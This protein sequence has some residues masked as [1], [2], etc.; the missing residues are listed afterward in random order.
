MEKQI[1][2]IEKSSEIVASESVAPVIQISQPDK[3]LEMAISKGADMDQLDKLLQLKERYD[4]EMARKAFTAAL[5]A[6]KTEDLCIKKDRTVTIET[7]DAGTYGYTHASLGNIVGTAVPIMSKHGL[8]HRW[9]TVQADARVKVT[10]ILTHRD[11]HSEQTTLEASPDTSGKKNG[12]QQ[13][14]STVTYLQRY[15]F[16]S[17]TG[18]AVEEMDNDGQG[19]E[20]QQI[21]P[22]KIKWDKVESA[23]EAFKEVVDADVDEMD[24]GR[25]QEGYRRLSND[26]QMAVFSKFGK[27][28]PEG[29]DLLY[30]SVI[31]KLLAMNGE[32]K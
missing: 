14:A 32:S 20:G 26:E 30:R 19:F 25:V 31:K 27:E 2:T 18:L 21:S 9:E 16:L 10:C 1:N 5:A 11:G 15:T 13:V 29:C 7:K 3:L 23:Y 24:Y 12:I 6:F 22:D 4:N 17:I 8:S 28:K